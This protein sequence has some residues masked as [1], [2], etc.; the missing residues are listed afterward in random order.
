MFSVY[1]VCILARHPCSW[2]L[3]PNTLDPIWL[4]KPGSYLATK[5]PCQLAVHAWWSVFLSLYWLGLQIYLYKFLDLLRYVFL[6]Q[7]LA[8]QHRFLEWKRLS[9]CAI[10]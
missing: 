5:R 1:S 3:E 9:D 10:Y 4:I 8:C 2:L 7:V 6:V